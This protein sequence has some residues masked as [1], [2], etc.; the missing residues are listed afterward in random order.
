MSSILVDTT[1]S[2]ARRTLLKL[3]VIGEASVG[4]TSLLLRYTEPS[5][6][7]HTEP[8]SV[9]VDNKSRDLTID[10]EPVRLQLWDTAGQE[11]F[12]VIT[13]TFYKGAHGVM[14]V[15]DRSNRESFETVKNWMS[16][17]QR[18]CQEPVARI[19]VG[20]KSDLA[21]SAPPPAEGEKSPFVTLEEAKKETAIFGNP[22]VGHTSIFDQQSVSV[23]FEELARQ[24]YALVEKER[25]AAASRAGS[26]GPMRPGMSFKVGSNGQAA[27]GGRKS[28]C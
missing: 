26:A 2:G 25:Q 21:D 17:I 19:V 8:P 9:G 1:G 4:K 20:N 28:K 18:Y 16:E 22:W 12:R 13:S 14:I 15:Y 27:S 6:D 24:A 23:A 5:W 10:K 11:K 7:P 3:L